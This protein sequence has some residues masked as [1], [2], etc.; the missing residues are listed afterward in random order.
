MQIAS[1]SLSLRRW[2]G[3]IRY[4]LSIV[5]CI[6]YTNRF[7]VPTTRVYM[8]RDA[9]ENANTR[10]EAELVIDSEKYLLR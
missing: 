2:C 1:V 6:F 4:A 10:S 3:L 8:L 9:A 7:R 5:L